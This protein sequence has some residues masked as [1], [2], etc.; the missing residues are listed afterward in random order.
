MQTNKPSEVSNMQF[1]Q[2]LSVKII[3]VKHR[4][5]LMSFIS[6]WN[7]WAQSTSVCPNMAKLQSSFN[8]RQQCD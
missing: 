8:L 5:Q 7:I 2:Q 3:Q 4:D 1:L 6:L